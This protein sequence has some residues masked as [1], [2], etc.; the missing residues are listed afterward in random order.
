MCVHTHLQTRTPV[1]PIL[2]GGTSLNP[3]KGGLS[4][5]WWHLGKGR[6]AA[7]ASDLTQFTGMVAWEGGDSRLSS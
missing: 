2:I 4:L 1:P 5:P 7:I 6:V 3:R